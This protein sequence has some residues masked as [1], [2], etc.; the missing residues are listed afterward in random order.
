M[1]GIIIL[2]LLGLFLFIV[3]FVLIPGVTVAGIAGL[4]CLV[5]GVYWAFASYGTVVGTI[6]LIAT[7]S[8]T[9]FT[10]IFALRS[11]TW[12]LFM[13]NTN[14]MGSVATEDLATKIKPGDE[15]ITIS[16]LSPMGKLRINNMVIE[17]SSTGEYIN[18]RTKVV[19]VRLSGPKVIVKPKID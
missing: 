6:T 12:R 17:A 11:K 4:G 3:E 15:G 9:L 8:V 19:V 10:V 14:V 18:P 7:V 1:A 2:I 16:R 5:G 13:L